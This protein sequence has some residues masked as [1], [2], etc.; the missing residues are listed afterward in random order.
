MADVRCP[1][2]GKPNPATAK[3]CQFCHARLQLNQSP[4]DSS[5]QPNANEP[6]EAV[7]DWLKSLRDKKEGE[8]QPA[9]EQPE[10]DWLKSL[11]G[12]AE[13]ET[14]DSS[15]S[16]AWPGE[17]ESQ[18]QGGG[19]PDWLK[20]IRGI[21]E[22]EAPAGEPP[23][24]EENA[25][26]LENIRSRAQSEEAYSPLNAPPPQ[27]DNSAPDWLESI[28]R[29]NELE[30]HV[31]QPP[32]GKGSEDEV[33][34]WL[35]GFQQPGAGGTESTGESAPAE[36]AEEIPSWLQ[37][38]QPPTGSAGAEPM[39]EPAPAESAEEI[40]AWLQGF[41]PG[42]D[43]T[44]SG[45][46]AEPPLP[47]QTGGA[48]EPPA[49]LQDLQPAA[50][51]PAPE[52]AD[53]STPAWIT[54]NEGVPDWLQPAES[55]PTEAAPEPSAEQAPGWL[56]RV[57]P[58]PAAE[59]EAPAESTVE[60][61]IETPDWLKSAPAQPAVPQEETAAPAPA[62]PADDTGLPDWLVSAKPVTAQPIGGTPAEGQPSSAVPAFSAEAPSQP[63]LSDESTSAGFLPFEG[64]SMPEWLSKI[65]TEEVT[66]PRAPEQPVAPPAAAE[67]Q[68]ATV[69]PFLES[70]LPDWLEQVRAP[71]PAKEATP[72]EQAGGASEGELPSWIQAMRPVEAVVPKT[73]Q[74]AVEDH[75]TETI[76]PLAGLEGVLP[77]PPPLA[78]F[79]KPPAY[80]VKLHVPDNQRYRS[81]L[82][83]ELL[84]NETQ[85]QTPV[86]AK[87]LSSQKIM[88][89]VVGGILLLAILGIILSGAI[90]SDL[91]GQFVPEL[92]QAK[93]LINAM[94]STGTALVVF[95][96]APALSGELEAS[97]SPVID[98]LM[99]KKVSLAILSTTPMGPVLGQTVIDKLIRENQVYQSVYL[100]KD[101]QGYYTKQVNLGYLIGGPAALQSFALA[102]V[103]TATFAFDG[104]EAWG[105]SPLQNIKALNNFSGVVVI[106]DNPDTAKAWIEQV[107]P[108]L[109][110]T[111][112]IVVSSAQAAPLIR[113]YFDGGQVQ[114]M[115]IGL[116]GGTYF[117]QLTQRMQTSRGYWNAYSGSVWVA[118]SLIILGG[119]FNWVMT[120]RP[121]QKTK[122]KL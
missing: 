59:P 50:A 89:W 24:A 41:A 44:P 119:L 99:N 68:P 30:D 96:Y 76:G 82:M 112:L 42:G 43:E 84:V 39:R 62:F 75:R 69:Q 17:S 71:E 54:S 58:S 11:S 51:A 40:P 66:P 118:F 103:K 98:L 78:E 104:I 32:A 81:S 2:C 53:E 64:E 36:S 23:A 73:D 3:E 12:P 94:P 93:D 19:T 85:P 1:M 55:Q 46:V 101:P 31:A 65:E 27:E 9:G 22:K 45:T 21:S 92:V 8:S 117:E 74:S 20:D 107:Q 49:W 14:P 111:P 57:Q 108:S 7:P 109:G 48:E 63:V 105:L 102:P 56:N 13:S 28:R 115:V 67:A 86:V 15:A 38:F 72:A 95:D 116:S 83:E 4:L 25:G 113:P 106:T 77:I 80:S 97:A 61:P 87:S 70:N 33:P 91:P 90:P 79:R 18:Q 10:S 88:R 16:P 60:P 100:S 122:G 121:R 5:A 47:A 52:P 120:L 34:A 37:G 114:G 29:R 35:Q 6:E 110:K 26:W